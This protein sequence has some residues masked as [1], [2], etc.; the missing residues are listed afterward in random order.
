MIPGT[1]LIFQ[2]ATAR[3]ALASGALLIDEAEMHA[4][5]LEIVYLAAR[6]TATVCALDEYWETI[7]EWDLRIAQSGF[8]VEITSDDPLPPAVEAMVREAL[9]VGRGWPWP[10]PN[11]EAQS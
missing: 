5:A 3:Y 6:G 1:S 8:T 2:E 9:P 7:H 11:K 4:S 10:K